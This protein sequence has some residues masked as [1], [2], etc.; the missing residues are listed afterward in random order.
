MAF[1]LPSGVRNGVVTGSSQLAKL[2]PGGRQ[3]DLTMAIDGPLW[4]GD[5]SLGFIMSS[6][7]R[8]RQGA[9]T[10]YAIFTGRPTN[11]AGRPHKQLCKLESEEWDY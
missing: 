9:D 8:H 11:A 10:E 2:E 7:Q 5:L 4:S 6:H 1:T 3:V